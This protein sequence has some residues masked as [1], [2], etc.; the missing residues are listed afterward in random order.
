MKLFRLFTFLFFVGLPVS[1]FTL[2]GKVTHDQDVS[3]F[4]QS[5]FNDNTDFI[6]RISN[7]DFKA[8]AQGQNPR[9]TVVTCSDSRIQSDVF[10]KSPVND[11]FFVRNIGNQIVT[12][13]GSVE[14]GIYHLH[15][16]VLLI[17]GHSNCGAIK[18]AMGDY[19]Q[20]LAPIREELDHLHLPKGTDTNKAIID[21]VHRQVSFALK[22]FKDKIE[23]KEL[24]VVGTVYDFSDSY[25]KGH[26]RLILVNLNGEKNAIKI[27]QDPLLKNIDIKYWKVNL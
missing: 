25:H 24:T 26:G 4:L 27:K 8:L 20:E 10:H 3:Q 15:T 11:L 14:Y 5:I 18:A 21:N 1:A 16:P 7:Q 2:E 17:I 12:T 19:S 6:N 9:A 13:E 22:K 23:K